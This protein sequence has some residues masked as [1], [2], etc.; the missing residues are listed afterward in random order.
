MLG[1]ENR[2]DKSQALQNPR[3][4]EVAAAGRVPV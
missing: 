4:N 2:E 3:L 1:N